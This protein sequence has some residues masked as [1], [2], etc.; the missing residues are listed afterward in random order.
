[1]NITDSGG[2]AIGLSSFA[3]GTLEDISDNCIIVPAYSTPRVESF[4]VA[5]AY[6]ICTCLQENIEKESW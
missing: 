4:Q 5:L 6:L 3:S 2:V 1:M